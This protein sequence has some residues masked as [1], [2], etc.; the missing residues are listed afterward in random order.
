[1]GPRRRARKLEQRSRIAA[2]CVSSATLMSLSHR[3]SLAAW[4]GAAYRTAPCVEERLKRGVEERDGER[5]RQARSR[6]L[7]SAAPDAFD[8]VRMVDVAAPLTHRNDE[9][10]PRASRSS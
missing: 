5:P 7:L 4:P 6:R 3:L 8:S 9:C 10:S 2:S 1:M